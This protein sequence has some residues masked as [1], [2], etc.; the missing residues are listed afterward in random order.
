MTLLL[1]PCLLY[2]S[3]TLSSVSVCEKV[4]KWT[5][6]PLTESCYGCPPPWVNMTEI[7]HDMSIICTEAFQYGNL[8]AKLPTNISIY[9]ANR[10]D[11]LYL[12]FVVIEASLTVTYPNENR[13]NSQRTNVI[14]A[15]IMLVDSPISVYAPSVNLSLHSSRPTQILYLNTLQLYLMNVSSSVDSSFTVSDKLILTRGSVIN[16]S[17]PIEVEAL[18]LWDK[19]TLTCQGIDTVILRLSTESILSISGSL[20]A[21]TIT[22]DNDAL[23]SVTQ[24]IEADSI[25]INASVVT[26]VLRVTGDA[27]VH[28]YGAI[29]ATRIEF[30]AGAQIKGTISF[31]TLLFTQQGR[32]L[33]S[34]GKT[35]V[36]SN[37]C[38]P[39]TGYS[40]TR[41]YSVTLHESSRLQ[42]DTLVVD[43][44]ESF[45]SKS[46]SINVMQYFFCNLNNL[47]IEHRLTAP[48]FLKLSQVRSA[49][50]KMRVLIEHIRAERSRLYFEDGAIISSGVLVN[51]AVMKTSYLQVRSLPLVNRPQWLA[52]SSSDPQYLTEEPLVEILSGHRDS[53]NASRSLH[54]E[55][56]Y[57]QNMTSTPLEDEQFYLACIQIIGL[58]SN[59][60]SE[61]ASSSEDECLNYLMFKPGTLYIEKGYLLSAAL[62][63]ANVVIN[64]GTLT[65]LSTLHLNPPTLNCYV[66]NLFYAGSLSSQ[67]TVSLSFL[68]SADMGLESETSRKSIYMRA[69]KS[70]AITSLDIKGKVHVKHTWGSLGASGLPISIMSNL[71]VDRDSTF[72]GLLSVFNGKQLLSQATTIEGSLKISSTYVKQSEAGLIIASR[73]QAVASAVELLGY[74]FLSS[75]SYKDPTIYIQAPFV[76]LGSL[77]L[78]GPISTRRQFN[79]CG[80]SNVLFGGCSRGSP[81][82]L[83][84]TNLSL[85]KL[86]DPN[87]GQISG[88]P[89]D[90]CDGVLGGRAGGTAYI[91]ATAHL[92]L[93]GSVVANGEGGKS[94]K[95]NNASERMVCG[96]SG[97]GGNIYIEAPKVK[98]GS[99]VLFSVSGGNCTDACQSDCISTGGSSPGTV[100]VNCTACSSPPLF[101]IFADPGVC[102]IYEARNILETCPPFF[103]VSSD[104][105]HCILPMPSLLVIILLMGLLTAFLVLSMVGIV[106]WFKRA[107][108]HRKVT[109]EVNYFS[110]FD[111]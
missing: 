75:N 25:T 111:D 16:A 21:K 2:L 107:W 92:T 14:N 62:V 98:V 18:E 26:D 36:A 42:G 86:H 106:T 27:W 101:S 58:L 39:V 56:V 72:E 67:Y 65:R 104:R 19:S 5:D 100:T 76:S 15:T 103:Q 93:L 97:A 63:D 11:S 57:L 95:L 82:P 33:Q 83:V 40:R 20:S 7:L 66:H 77:V 8:I 51:L 30:S 108:M 6:E 9:A 47:L 34:T 31:V 49:L 87:R 94:S 110:I 81:A 68:S 13:A 60:T 38:L 44:L 17:T 23:V 71:S 29:T 64:Y 61:Q 55:N 105:L 74:V 52:D 90:T 85:Y 89:G 84:S 45:I 88:N 91:V 46:S 50:F 37:M 12:S 28:A 80:G 22:A 32:R 59:E 70:V 4:N 43:G 53:R 1:L 96:G 10:V 3:S 78:H 35:Q 73:L 48:G 79:C 102:G 69:Y 24:T 99:N 41:V 109:S 54:I